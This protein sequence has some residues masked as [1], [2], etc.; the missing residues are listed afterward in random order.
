M[1]I[2][3]E[4]WTE[5]LANIGNMF[6]NLQN[7]GLGHLT[8]SKALLALFAVYTTSRILAFFRNLKASL[9]PTPA[10]CNRSAQLD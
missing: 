9:V 3:A 5:G 7:A 2:L 4:T 8:V 1:N 10:N 6:G